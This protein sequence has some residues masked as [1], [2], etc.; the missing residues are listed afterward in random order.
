MIYVKTRIRHIPASCSKCGYYNSCNK[1]GFKTCMAIT[2]YTDGKIL[3]GG[4]A[5]RPDIAVT[6]ERPRWCPLRESDTNES[7]GTR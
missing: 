6:K 7:R 2:R 1:W 4:R 3:A 5:D